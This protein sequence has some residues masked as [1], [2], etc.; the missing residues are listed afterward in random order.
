MYIEDY[1]LS[2]NTVTLI[3]FSDY[4]DVSCELEFSYSTYTDYY[5]DYIGGR[6]VE[7]PYL[8]FDEIEIGSIKMYDEDGVRVS[9]GIDGSEAERLILELLRDNREKIEDW[10]KDVY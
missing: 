5:W 4:G 3:D 2:E 10:M 6:D 9:W 8:E 7:V 1:D